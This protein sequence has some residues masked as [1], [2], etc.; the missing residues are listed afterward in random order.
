MTPAASPTT[1]EMSETASST[2]RPSTFW[3]YE[4]AGRGAGEPK[5]SRT[6]AERT[7]SRISEHEGSHGRQMSVDPRG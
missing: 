3:H 2:S 1:H 6:V 7:P 5:A 4:S